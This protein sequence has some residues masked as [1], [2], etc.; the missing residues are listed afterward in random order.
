MSSEEGGEGGAFAFSVGDF[1]QD[2]VG[3][4]NNGPLP[5]PKTYNGSLKACQDIALLRFV[6]QARD[7]D[8]L[9]FYNGDWVT[10]NSS[11]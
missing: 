5:C 8:K 6:G 7:D 2:Q 3:C 9:N 4:V 11:R 10:W 1:V